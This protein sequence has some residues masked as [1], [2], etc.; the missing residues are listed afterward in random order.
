MLKWDL[1][2]RFEVQVTV[3]TLGESKRTAGISVGDGGTQ[4]NI[5]VWISTLVVN[6][7]MHFCLSSKRLERLEKLAKNKE[8]LKK[9]H[10]SYNCRVANKWAP[11]FNGGLSVLAYSL[12]F[13][14]PALTAWKYLPLTFYLTF[15]FDSWVGVN[16]FGRKNT[17]LL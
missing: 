17:L 11:Q 6:P 9:T 10:R 8:V 1:K 7:I 4:M 16:I 2:K 12:D 3:L 14:L 5:L 13:G 15:S